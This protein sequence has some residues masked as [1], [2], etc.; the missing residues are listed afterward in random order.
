MGRSVEAGGLDPW[1]PLPFTA[2]EWG[3]G[4]ETLPPKAEDCF[5]I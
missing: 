4:A 2:P 1:T 5:A 3:A